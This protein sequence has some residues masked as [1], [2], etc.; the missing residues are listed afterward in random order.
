M[1]AVCELDRTHAARQ[2]AGCGQTGRFGDVVHNRQVGT[3]RDWLAVPNLDASNRSGPQEVTMSAFKVTPA[4]LEAL[5][6]TVGRVSTDVRAQHQNLRG[7]L[8]PLFGAEWAGAA[9]AQ[10]TALYDQFDLHA[11]GMSDA[12]DGIGQLLARAGVAYADVEQQI[13]ASFR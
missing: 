8:A 9:S 7:Q 12:L 6:T 13:A 1:P 10:F 4:Q 11:R 5:G 2:P 3:V